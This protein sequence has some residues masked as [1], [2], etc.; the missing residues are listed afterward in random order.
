[1]VEYD[2][3][4]ESVG[5]PV[6]LQLPST[7]LASVN[8][9]FGSRRGFRSYLRSGNFIPDITENSH[10]PSHG[11]ISLG[12]ILSGFARLEITKP[13]SRRSQQ[14]QVSWDLGQIEIGYGDIN[15]SVVNHEVT[16]DLQIGE[17]SLDVQGST[18]IIT[19][20]IPSFGYLVVNTSHIQY[21]MQKIEQRI[22]FEVL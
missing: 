10:I 2:N 6:I 7:S 21:S 18:I 20:T 14:S 8:E 22:P 19:A 9:F 13:L 1:M 17:A 5:A 3:A 11:V 12:S 4:Q 15:K 16:M